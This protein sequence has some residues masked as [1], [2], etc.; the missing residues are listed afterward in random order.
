MRGSER[1]QHTMLT[2]SGPVA[3]AGMERPPLDTP[4]VR[5]RAAGQAATLGDRGVTRA[6]P[7][8]RD[9]AQPSQR[10][11]RRGAGNTLLWPCSADAGA[12]APAGPRLGWRSSR[13]QCAGL[14]QER[15]PP[16]APT[17][18]LVRAVQAAMLRK[19]RALGARRDLTL[20]GQ[21][22]RTP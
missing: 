15:A 13:R 8:P 19:A 18:G 3:A 22:R 7:G 14:T 11:Q 6:Q 5:L 17:S 10:Q 4:S 16:C 2:E 21:T 12:D 9:G 1:C 20:P